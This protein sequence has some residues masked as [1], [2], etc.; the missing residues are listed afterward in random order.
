MITKRDIEGWEAVDHY[1]VVLR[2]AYRQGYLNCLADIEGSATDTI[3][4]ESVF[5]DWISEVAVDG[6]VAD[7]PIFIE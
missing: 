3:I 6:L 5:D 1:N 7:I 2:E 4:S